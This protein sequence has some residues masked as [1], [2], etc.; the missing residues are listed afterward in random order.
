V[1][2]AVAA[3]ET[4]RAF[5]TPAAPKYCRKFAAQTGRL[6]ARGDLAEALSVEATSH[7]PTRIIEISVNGEPRDVAAGS[8]VAGL[9]AE[10]GLAGRKIA[11]A[12]GRDVVP[13]GSYA[14]R[15]L[16]AGDRVEILEA[17]GGG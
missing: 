10:L 14:A 16:R 15:V 9:I 13:R 12:V 3:N 17:V 8:T 6:V 11:V 5:D 7:T 2:H 4:A 1:K